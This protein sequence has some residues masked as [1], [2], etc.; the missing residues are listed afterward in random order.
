MFKT[1]II[2]T[3]VPAE[4]QLLKLI[5]ESW[6]RDADKDLDRVAQ[7]AKEQEAKGLEVPEYLKRY[8]PR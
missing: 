2:T 5:F 4:F 8:L 3:S 6:L 1:T 7:W